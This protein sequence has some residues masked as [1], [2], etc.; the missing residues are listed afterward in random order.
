MNQ[1]RQDVAI[2]QPPP[3]PG[4]VVVLDEA[5]C[6]GELLVGAHA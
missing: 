6:Y 1:G 5:I 4:A 2:D 3:R